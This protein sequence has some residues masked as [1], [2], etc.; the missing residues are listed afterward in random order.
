MLKHFQLKITLF[1]STLGPPTAETKEVKKVAQIGENLR[2]VCPVSAYPAPIVEWS[3]NGDKID[4]M[5]ER[6]KTGKK[7]LKIKNLSEDDTGIFE[8]KAVNGF[9]VETVRIELI[10]V[11]KF[12]FKKLKMNKLS[13]KIA[14]VMQEKFYI[15][16]KLDLLCYLSRV[17]LT[18]KS[19]E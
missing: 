15:F 9:G 5:W 3:K 6:H 10:V 7:W 13:A 14:N 8:C 19:V 18:L 2:L 4:F 12:N 16:F 11:G 1:I 17:I